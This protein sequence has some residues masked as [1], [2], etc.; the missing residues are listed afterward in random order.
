MA[1]LFFSGASALTLELVFGRLLQ[2]VFGVS[3]LAIATVLAAYFLGLGLGS[4]LGAALASRLAD[5]TRAYAGMEAGIALLSL[6]SLLLIP[7]IHRLHAGLPLTTSFFAL[8]S[9]RFVAALL[10]LLPSTVLMGATLP[11]LISAAPRA[12]WVSQAS[13]LYGVNT[14]GAVTGAGAAGLWLLPLLG[15]RLLVVV[16]AALN[17]VAGAIVLVAFRRGPQAAEDPAPKLAEPSAESRPTFAIW[18]AFSSGLLALVGEVVWTRVLR[19]IVQGTTQA[20]AAM[21]VCTLSG[22]ALGAFVAAR[23]TH[24][25]R[26]AAQR[27]GFA[28]LALALFSALGL[29][30]TNALPQLVGR[31]SP[32]HALE[33]AS[34]HAVLL[35]SASVLL[36]ISFASGTVI[37]FAWQIAGIRDDAGESAGRVLAANTVGGLLGALLAGFALVPVLGVNV[38]VLCVI[39]AH[40]AIASVSFRAASGTALW[41]RVGSL[42]GPFALGVAI[43]AARPAIDLAYLAGAQAHAARATER[44]RESWYAEQTLRLWEGRNTTVT[45]TRDGDSL[46]LFND[47]RPESGFSPGEPGYGPELSMLGVLPTTFAPSLDRALVVGLGAGHS[48]DVMLRAPWKAVDVAELEPAIVEASRYLYDARG[49]RW[50]MSDPRTHLYVDDARAILVRSASHSYDA[51]VSQPSHPWLAGSSALYTREFFAETKRALKPGGVLVLWIN[52]FRNEISVIRSV[53]RTL[54]GSYA[55]VNGYRVEESSFIFA[56][57]DRALAFN[58][59]VATRCDAMDCAPLLGTAEPASAMISGMEFDDA[60]AEAFARGAAVYTDDRPRLE[61]A[62]AGVAPNRIVGDAAVDGALRGEPWL[63]AQA[64]ASPSALMNAVPATRTRIIKTMDRPLALERVDRTLALADLPDAW[65]AELRG[66][67]AQARGQIEAALLAYDSAQ[68]PS[69]LFAADAL[70]LAEG[71]YDELVSRATAREVLPASSVPMLRATFAIEDRTHTREVLTR[72]RAI[73]SGPDTSLLELA[74]AR[75]AGCTQ[76]LSSPALQQ[77]V[78]IE[79]VAIAIERCEIASGD[80]DRAARA[81][82]HRQAVQSHAADEL[83]AA[84]ERAVRTGNCV[85]AAVLVRRAIRLGRADARTQTLLARCSEGDAAAVDVDESGHR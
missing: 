57:S 9:I 69:A 23:V 12:K 80:S 27:L 79:E 43:L 48:V 65:T 8:T 53:V 63:S 3:D 54:R 46:R 82:T 35:V 59:S 60:G 13:V 73:I 77:H 64:F 5:K 67:L 40:L 29:V 39:F 72:A 20:F 84:A 56:A 55:H 31:L 41:D 2:R 50:P 16:A 14:L 1:A 66:A 21:L 24:S 42:V 37:P 28:Q 81:T 25:T 45:V 32:L 26:A 61:Y 71:Q 11:V 36:P 75:E 22:I 47:G 51:I 76:F 33:A 15:A 58:E 10:V 85:P 44:G 52:L 17:L 34:P 6:V 18:V 19:L 68:T 74:T 83:V 38:T 4:R 70:R 30:T 78:D 49:R 7:L 62:L